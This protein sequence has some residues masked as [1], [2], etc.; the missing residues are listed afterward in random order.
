MIFQTGKLLH[1]HS[2][3][4]P[5]LLHLLLHLSKYPRVPTCGWRKHK[6]CCPPALEPAP[7]SSPQCAAPF[8][9]TLNS[10]HLC[11]FCKPPSHLIAK[12]LK[13][14]W[15]RS[16]LAHS[17]HRATSE[18]GYDPMGMSHC[19]QNSSVYQCFPISI[20]L[21]ALSWSFILPNSAWHSSSRYPL[22]GTCFRTASLPALSSPSNRTSG[23]K[24][25]YMMQVIKN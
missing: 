4:L 7:H 16:S 13:L 9:S 22:L 1:L 11:G 21:L 6:L 15:R 17:H 3:Y 10:A 12:S 8:S 18:P 14:D 19:T 24:A 5:L 20:S 23:H 25:H 2:P